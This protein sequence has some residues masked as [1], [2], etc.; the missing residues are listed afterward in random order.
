MPL[1]VVKIV[2]S[3][4]SKIKLSFDCPLCGKTNYIE[5]DNTPEFV[6]GWFDYFKN[7]M[8]IQNAFPFLNVDQREFF[9]TGN[10]ECI[11]GKI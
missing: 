8:S 1:N 9:M 10:C 5:F 3:T 4:D 2:S 6:K 7:G 11:W